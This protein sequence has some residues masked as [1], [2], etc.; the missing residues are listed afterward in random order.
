MGVQNRGRCVPTD[1]SQ[2][3]S[4]LPESVHGAKH[5]GRRHS[6]VLSK[7]RKNKSLSISKVTYY[8]FQCMLC[9]D[10]DVWYP[11]MEVE[12]DEYE[13]LLEFLASCGFEDEA[14]FVDRYYKEDKNGPTSYYHLQVDLQQSGKYQSISKFVFDK[15]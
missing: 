11:P 13:T 15:Q 3:T 12:K 8:M 14:M 2:R 5:S 6:I 9:E 10:E 1:V 4:A 7:L